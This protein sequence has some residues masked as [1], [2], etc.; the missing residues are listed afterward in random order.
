MTEMHTQTQKLVLAQEEMRIQL[1]S[2]QRTI[3]SHFSHQ[4]QAQDHEVNELGQ[5]VSNSPILERGGSGKR[6]T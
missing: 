5:A 6:F 4:Q 2:L 3:R 1:D